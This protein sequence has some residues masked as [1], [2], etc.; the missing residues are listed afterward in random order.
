MRRRSRRR[1][2][3]RHSSKRS[4]CSRRRR[5]RNRCK[6]SKHSSR[7]RPPRRQLSP[8]SQLPLHRQDQRR[9]PSQSRRRKRPGKGLEEPSRV[10]TWA[11][12]RKTVQ[13]PRSSMGMLTRR[14]P[15]KHLKFR[16]SRKLNSLKL[17]R[18]TSPKRSRSRQSWPRWSRFPRTTATARRKP[19]R[20]RRPLTV[21]IARKSQRKR[22]N[23]IPPVM[24]DG[25]RERNLIV[26]MMAPRKKPK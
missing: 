6:R 1:R 2:K 8:L 20:R 25:R 23:P 9:R 26:L 19:R 5:K 15:K 16:Q 17:S 21:Q 7:R 10:A 11:K 18:W 22:R 14:N 24:R 12:P 4:R 13:C 3:L